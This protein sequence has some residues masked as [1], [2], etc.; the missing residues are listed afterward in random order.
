VLDVRAINR[1]LKSV[2][3]NSTNP[4][5]LLREITRALAVNRRPR[6]NAA[7]VAGIAEFTSDAGRMEA[8]R[9]VRGNMLTLTMISE[10]VSISVHFRNFRIGYDLVRDLG[11][12]IRGLGRLLQFGPALDDGLAGDRLTCHHARR[13]LGLGK[14]RNGQDG[15]R[16]QKY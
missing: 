12:L 3:A 6:N 8:T 10:L 9:N 16:Y 14:T 13:R 2:I 5:V 15:S 1:P 11:E 7:L 4:T